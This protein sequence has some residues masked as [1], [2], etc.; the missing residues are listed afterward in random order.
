MKKSE[1]GQ[2]LVE[3]ALIIVL[4]IVVVFT[5]ISAA[6][7]LLVI[8]FAGVLALQPWAIFVVILGLVILLAGALCY[9]R[10]R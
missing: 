1:L 2:G 8:L 3:W 5:V 7:P 9:I 10:L 6:W 4:L